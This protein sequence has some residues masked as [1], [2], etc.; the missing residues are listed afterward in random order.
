M[1]LRFL[2][3][4]A[5]HFKGGGSVDDAR[6]READAWA[7]DALIPAKLWNDHAARLHPSVANVVDLA[8]QAKVHPAVVAGRIR[9]E[10]HSYR[11]LSQFVGANEVRPLLMAEVA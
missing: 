10:R 11:L 5:E 6:E 8:H 3:I 4:G 1:V 7:Q 9:Y 2:T